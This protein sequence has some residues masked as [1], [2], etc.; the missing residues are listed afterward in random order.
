ME[1]AAT[2]RSVDIA[3]TGKCNLRCRY[4][5]HFSS[6]AD[7]D[8]D[9]RTE[10]WLGFFRELEE[11]GVT[12]VTIGGGEPFIRSDMRELMEGIVGTRMRFT[13][14]SNGALISDDMAGCIGSTGRCDSVQISI[15][16]PDAR[17]HD[18]CRGDGSLEGAIRAVRLLKRHNV[19]VAV[20][21]TI[22]RHNVHSLDD[23]A[24]ILFEDLELP[25]FTTNSASP[26][27]LCRE[28][29]GD[30]LLT[31][32]ERSLA[33]QKLLDLNRKYD[34]RIGGSAG[35]LAEA[36]LWGGMVKARS[37][38]MPGLPD[39][40]VLKGCNGV[41]HRL[42][43]RADGI[44]APCAQLAHLE[45]GRINRDSLVRVWQDHPRLGRLRNRQSI[46]LSDFEF[47]TGCEY[48]PFCTGNCPA[49]SYTALG[50]EDHPCPDTCLRLF[51]E[52]GGRLPM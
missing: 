22:H 30:I 3:I 7:V 4:C 33:M 25:G 5:S 10:E 29:A 12:S 27:G 20:R 37:S 15:D 11:N 39:R 19:A 18:V 1:V 45:L 38:G 16:G 47:C 40:G 41:F 32:E 52:Q 44:L 48:I 49:L 35:P 36:R 2:P 6:A 23:V 43:V 24:K 28:N 31:V 14:L 13:I 21:V 9:V 46:P 42:A 50:I 34:G 26:M 8:N 17:T 51:L